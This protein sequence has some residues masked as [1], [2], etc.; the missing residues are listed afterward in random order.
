[1]SDMAISKA[2]TITAG[3]DRFMEWKTKVG[4]Y[5]NTQY[6]QFDTFIEGMF[7]KKRF[8]DILKTLF[9]SQKMLKS[10]QPIINTLQL[11]RQL[12]QLFRQQKVM[13]EVVFSGIHK[14]V[15]NRYQWFS[16]LIYFKRY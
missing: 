6:A 2:G 14:V 5:E 8:L 15:G 10:Y 9:V 1:M 4:S 3:E 12:T 11:E 7:E 13:D 16:M